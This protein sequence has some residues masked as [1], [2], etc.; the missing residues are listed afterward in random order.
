MGPAGERVLTLLDELERELDRQGSPFSSLAEP[1]V[2]P[3]RID[4]A[5]ERVG[6][7]F[8]DELRAWWMWHDGVRYQRG[9][10]AAHEIGVGGF[11]PYSLE[12]TMAEW[13]VWSQESIFR[14]DSTAE[15]TF[16]KSWLPFAGSDQYK[17]LNAKLDL[18]SPERLVMGVV[19]MPWE[20][21][22]GRT[23]DVAFPD[24]IEG[25]IGY[26]QAGHVRWNAEEG[27][28]QVTMP[29]VPGYDRL[30]YLP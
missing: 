27:Y 3:W 17:R 22:F 20:G 9:S 1:P 29:P 7:P 13:V 21:E 30:L 14:E 24:L 26:L 19:E 10:P 23:V 18:S 25:W 28:W 2:A 5:E 15:F 4:E 12:R 8:P 16:L 6:F 11:E